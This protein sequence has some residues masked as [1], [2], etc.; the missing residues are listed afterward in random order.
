MHPVVRPLL[1]GLLGLLVPLAGYAQSPSARLA[2][3]KALT[4]YVHRVWND[5]DGLPHST[6]NAVAQTPDGY[7]WVG[8]EGG[9]VRFN[10]ADFEVFDRSN[11]EAFAGG[12]NIRA[13]RVDRQGTLWVGTAGAGLV[14]YAAGRFE[15]VT[16]PAALQGAHVSVLHEDAAGT[17]WV[18]TFEDGLFRAYEGGIEPVGG[19]AEG[20]LITALH[21]DRRG[22]LWVGTSDGLF[23]WAGEAP[24]AFRPV[25][26]LPGPFV[27]ALGEDAAGRLWV[28]TRSG[29]ARRVDGTV[30]TKGLPDA[31]DGVSAFAFWADGTG[32]LWLGTDGRGL[33]RVRDGA[34]EALT[35]E[36]GLLNDR[37][38]AVFQDREGSL[39]FG[40]EGGGLNQLRDG[41][42]TP[43]GTPEGL[44]SDMILAVYEDAAENLWLGTEGGGV[45]RI[46]DGRVTT[47][48]TDEG[49]S[50]DVVLS[51]H[52]D[53]AGTL[54]VGTYGGGVNRY[55]DGQ[56]TAYTTQDGFISDAVFALHRGPSGALWMGTD[57]G[58][59]RYARGT[60]RYFTEDDGLSSNLISTLHEDADG[61][62]W[63]GTFPN[64]LDRFRGG[65]FSHLGP[66]DGLPEGV[67]TDI[68]EDSTGTLWLGTRG[69]GL[70]R[71][72]DS[73]ITTFTSRDGLY[74]D[75]IYQLLEDAQGRL[76]MGTGKGIFHLPRRTLDAYAA[77][78]LDRLDPV[79]FTENDGLRTDEMNGGVQ[80][81][82]WRRADGTLWFPTAQGVAGIDPDAMQRNDVPPPVAIEAVTV[83]DEAVARGASI[84]LVPGTKKLNV[85]FAAPTFIAPS[86]V[87]YQYRLRGYDDT[88][89][90][91]T[92]SRM[93]T[94]TNLDPGAYTFEVRARNADGVPSAQAAVQAFTQQPFFYETP[95][96]W[97]VCVL[98]L[99]ALGIGAYRARLR[100]LKARQQELEALVA[101]RTEELREL[102]VHLEDKVEE[103]LQTILE[104]REKYEARLR[105]EKE[106][107]EEAARLKSAILNN[108]SHEFRTP[109]TGILGYAD[110]LLDEVDEAYRDFAQT[111]HDYGERLMNTLDAVLEL[112]RL[113][114]AATEPQKTSIDVGEL[115]HGVAREVEHDAREHGLVFEADLPDAPLTAELDPTAFERVLRILTDNAVKF[116]PE[117]EVRLEVTAG[118]DSEVV[119]VHVH[120][121]GVGIS[122]DFRPHLFEPFRQESM[123]DQRAFEGNGLNLSIAKRLVDLIGGGITVESTKDVG[124]TFTVEMPRAEGAERPIPAPQGDGVATHR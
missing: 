111:I 95:T 42:F 5:D 68:H 80:P 73:T 64:G 81:A 124:T 65:T 66:S 71:M 26:G 62:L 56:F 17:L 4:Q 119:R 11:T 35:S 86:G 117:G 2:P 112:A 18:G 9:V 89:S 28:S 74:S 105:H 87:Q 63:I 30:Q 93:A 70:V 69:G 43:Y 106:R 41:K 116:T 38:V 3:D 45:S 37:V 12:H 85:H 51:V 31:L 40:T 47:L 91:W 118:P 22:T 110:I 8:T 97:A 23:R 20:T 32:S 36:H 108:M 114:A 49:L 15:P 75:N 113:E 78:R 50:S 61:T 79:V 48:T 67:V 115:A 16:T 83:D 100:H 59:A 13:L 96:F 58:I 82:A 6:V 84:E 53:A 60:F 122:D 90:T 55:A 25:E 88:W 10:G 72:R 101:A 7:L 94:Y 98:G 107:A 99:L 52:E 1:I 33:M 44:R 102:N 57:A 121:T 77:G 123:G 19:M 27:V 104:E 54:W 109:M 103:Q 39:W 34:A 14:R 76:W 24:Q 120:D 92:A 21:S 46:R 29:L